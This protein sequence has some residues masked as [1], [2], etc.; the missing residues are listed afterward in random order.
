MRERV[1]L[2]DGTLEINSKPGEG[3]TVSAVVPLDGE[4]A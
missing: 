4:V 2:L 1:R 3:T